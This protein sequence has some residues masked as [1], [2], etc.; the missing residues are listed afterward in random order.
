MQHDEERP[1]ERGPRYDELHW[2]SGGRDHR[3]TGMRSTQ[4]DG[5]FQA[6]LAGEHVPRLGARMGVHA[7]IIARL[8]NRE[9][10]EEF[11]G[12]S[13]WHWRQ[14]HRRHAHTTA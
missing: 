3:L 9:G 8:E 12:L 2:R 5:G 14:V 1:P 4:T 6:L 13:L 7:Y 10:G 11:V